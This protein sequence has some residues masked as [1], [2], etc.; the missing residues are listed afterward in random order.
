[1]AMTDWEALA[2]LRRIDDGFELTSAGKEELSSF[3]EI[4]WTRV[5]KIPE[6]IGLMT[7]LKA[8]D[9]SGEVLLRSKLTTIPESIGNL[10]GLQRLNLSYTQISTLPE[11][12]EDLSGLQRLNLS[13]TQISMLPESIGNLSSLQ[14]LDLRSTQISTLPESIGN[15]SSLQI[16]YLSSTQISTLPGS[17][18]NLSN[19]QILDLSST[20]I[21][22]LPESIG[23]LSSLQRL[24]LNSMRISTLPES[25][26]NLSSLQD[27]YLTGTQIS[28]LPESIGN[29]SSL[30]RLDL[31]YSQTSTLPESIGNL[32]SLQRLDLSYSQTSTL[33]ES[34]GNL[35]SLWDLNLSKTQINT[36]P[37]SIGNLS[38]LQ[39]LDL[40]F[41]QI[42]TL[43][44]VIGDLSKL[45][46]LVLENLALVELPESLLKLNLEY[47]DTQYGFSK[48]PGVYINGLKLQNQPIEV[49]SQRREI[50]IEY[51]K[52]TKEKSTSP[53]NECKVVFLGDGGAGK[54]L[55]IDRLMK[56][57]EISLDNDGEV[58][59]G[60]KITSKKYQIDGDEIELHFWDFGGQ[61]IMHSIHRL[62]LTKRT[63]Y[64][65][66]TNA[67]DNKSNEQ[68]WYW[69]RNIKSFANG[70]P[71]L[72]LINQKDQNPSAYIDETGIRKEYPHIKGVEIVSALKDT[73][74]EFNKHIR[75]VIC[76]IV[77]EME[78][79]HTPF[80]RPWLSLMNDLQDMPEDYIDSTVFRSK[81][82]DNGIDTQQ[83][84][85]DQ[86]ISWY[87]DLGACFY[88][89]SNPVARKYMVLKPRW[90]LNAI[91]ILAFNGR[92]Y[93]KNGILSEE[94]IY[95]LI[96][97]PVPDLDVKKVWTDI[98]YKRDEIQY[99]LNVLINFNLVYRI[100]NER[101][102]VPMLCDE[103]E[104]DIVDE[105]DT[106]DAI[107]VS[108]RYDYLPENVIHRLMVLH[109]DELNTEVVWKTGALFERKR[110]NWQALARIKDNCLDVYAKAGD[111][112][113]HPINA[114]LDI[115]RE[116]VHKINSDFGLAAYEYMSVIR[117]RIDDFFEQDFE[118]YCRVDAF[119]EFLLRN[120]TDDMHMLISE[121][122]KYLFRITEND[123]II[124]VHSD[125]VL[126]LLLYH[127]WMIDTQ[128]LK[129]QRIVVESVD[130][131]SQE[132][133]D[134]Q[135]QPEQHD[136]D[137]SKDDQ[138]QD[139]ITP[140][141]KD[142]EDATLLVVRSFQEW[143]EKKLNREGKN[144][145]IIQQAYK[146]T[147]GEQH[148]YDVGFELRIGE[149]TYKLGFECKD[150]TSNIKGGGR[151]SNIN[152]RAYAINL[153]KYFINSKPQ[154]NNRW[155]L[156]NPFGDLQNDYPDKLFETWN[157]RH[158]YLRIFAI[159]E[160]QVYPT[161]EDF[162]SVNESA[163]QMVYPGGHI[164]PEKKD[165][166]DKIFSFIYNTYIGED[167]VSIDIRKKLK[168]YSFPN[169]FICTQSSDFLSERTGDGNN[170]LQEILSFLT[171]IYR[172]PDSKSNKNGIYIIGEYGTGKTWLLYRTI[173]EIINHPVKYPFV[174]VLMRLKEVPVEELSN[175][176]ASNQ[177]IHSV[178]EKYVEGVLK[179]QDQL[180]DYSMQY[181]SP[182]FLLDG[183]DEVLSGL[184]ATNNKI[185]IL[186]SIRD[187]IKSRYRK[188]NPVF[189]V[190]SRESDF[191]ACQTNKEFIGLFGQFY[192]ITLEDCP[193][194]EAK[195]KLYK[196]AKNTDIDKKSVAG[197]IEN[198]N[199]LGLAC[200]PVFYALLIQLL[201]S[202]NSSL[203]EVVDEFSL[204][205]NAIENEI[206]RS[207][208]ELI[209]A[210]RQANVE[211]L[212]QSLLE[213][214]LNCAIDCTKNNGNEAPITFSRQE[215][216][217]I[218]PNGLVSVKNKSVESATPD[219]P[220]T[221]IAD[222]YNEC[223]V[224]FL[225][226]IVREFLVAK[227]FYS[228][229]EE[230][231]SSETKEQAFFDMLSAVQMSP[232][233]LRFFLIFIQKSSQEEEIKEKLMYWLCRPDIKKEETGLPTKLLE[234]LL[235][236]DCTFG[237][238]EDA[239]LDLSGIRADNLCI[240][241]CKL[242]HLILKDAHLRNMQMTDTKLVDVDLR[243]AD[244]S[245]LRLAP[246][247]PITDISHYKQ[248]GEWHLTVLYQNGQVLKYTF[249]NRFMQDSYSVELLQQYEDATG[250]FMINDIQ[251]IVISG[252]NIYRL[253]DKNTFE[254]E[255]YS[256]SS[257][258]SIQRIIPEGECNSILVMDENDYSVQI[259]DKKSTVSYS[260]SITDPGHYYLTKNGIL[261]TAGEDA[262]KLIF[263]T[264][265]A[266]NLYKWKNNYECFT[267]HQH[268][269][270]ENNI[271]IK[272]NDHLIKII[273][274]R[275]FDNVQSPIEYRID[276]TCGTMR[277]IRVIKDDVLVG[278]SEFDL[279]IMTI[280]ADAVIVEKVNTTVEAARVRLEDQDG[281]NRMKDKEAYE[282]M[283]G[284]IMT[285]DETKQY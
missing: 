253:E 120:D 247:K 148:G 108:F 245:G 202:G 272:T 174:P 28:A 227:K 182:V 143:V 34:I 205:N 149:A 200:R 29:L 102:F 58:T 91:Y 32:S 235:Q 12:I 250:L 56:D 222:R 175:N 178:A 264:G 217:E 73:K 150:Y 263:H 19:L 254:N 229:I 118:V 169:K 142:L 282:L 267:I 57:G 61:A 41:T 117:N 246:S 9:V 209:Q 207:I 284:S 198:Q 268:S 138:N 187:I 269:S 33:P 107:H 265:T 127:I 172:D 180:E 206:N 105:F 166:K 116:S 90:L 199:I 276:G 77:S 62:F 74:K 10:S 1:M 38:S 280:N 64:V 17:I 79:V 212:R 20:Q 210:N 230:C 121:E 239:L 223:R 94:Y 232:A 261:V 224:S 63:L 152:I 66:V 25:I 65:V 191:H 123:S 165:K 204:L 21:S 156:V 193:V 129:E 86:I 159:T 173:V 16:L 144:Y 51:Y 122:L 54:S 82:R 194:S 3:Q 273:L 104:P 256:M 55:I 208:D 22:T 14:N 277:E 42:S 76:R 252:K 6:S 95:T 225:H 184:S 153:L 31:S 151:N 92:R 164:S 71:V 126:Q 45:Q 75:D 130:K 146:Q 124:P 251:Y 171:D 113:T 221:F 96:C 168:R 279:Y 231:I 259:I 81:C 136:N 137:T 15:L 53:I 4:T 84:T 185:R 167:Y 37:E 237:G 216:V 281:T 24:D 23:N 188:T 233:S 85:L 238:S 234:L 44:E 135:E 125:P 192:K 258:K 243:G 106:E 278:I 196:Y 160:T 114:Y 89:K 52:S 87:Q 197:L 176:D 131:T 283:A 36:L 50:I 67:R 46:I 266:K 161:C 190:T 83:E 163:Y 60:I 93:A 139:L 78:S 100:D 213:S 236:P 40:S 274:D 257:G 244:L 170:A 2:L 115:I 133:L 7:G 49:F 179:Q 249:T 111:Q 43:P 271:Y 68:A 112:K 195:A 11:S 275:Q 35:S 162:F 145:R 99:I 215:L 242:Q 39:S 255:L 241:N 8:L 226:N 240:W 72:L 119:Q 80:A 154:I 103:N 157:R 88:S 147:S 218:I 189:I 132:S 260:L 5:E 30:Q 220:W 228:L 69:I 201:E 101:F 98:R 181:M 211:D 270:G 219:R 141:S 203:E 128:R 155:V 158:S 110:L 97:E 18:G 59:P 262:I 186:L 48:E 140:S 109:G 70:A 27:L 183:F 248:N 177:L 13:S 134:K 47:K 214:L 285:F 26:G